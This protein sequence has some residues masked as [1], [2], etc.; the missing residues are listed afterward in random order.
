MA[1]GYRLSHDRKVAVDFRARI[2]AAIESCDEA[3]LQAASSE[4]RRATIEGAEPTFL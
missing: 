3:E 1:R 2:I 4:H